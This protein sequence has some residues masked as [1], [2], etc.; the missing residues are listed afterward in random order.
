MV[1]STFELKEAGSSFAS[2]PDLNP[3]PWELL[4]GQRSGELLINVQAS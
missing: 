1:D 4:A 3:V 2:Y